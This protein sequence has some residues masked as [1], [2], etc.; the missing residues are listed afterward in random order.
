MKLIKAVKIINFSKKKIMFNSI[1]FSGSLSI[2][3]NTKNLDE[4][5][6]MLRYVNYRLSDE[7]GYQ[8]TYGAGIT[9][10]TA[11]TI[12]ET[13]KLDKTLN[14]I[15]NNKPI[16]P[17]DLP[18]LA[19]NYNFLNKYL[20]KNF[21]G[22]EDIKLF[23]HN[24]KIKIIGTW[25]EKY[26]YGDNNSTVIVTGDYD[27]NENKIFNLTKITP[28]FNFQEMEK[29]W[30]YFENENNKLQVIY[31]WYPLQICEIVSNNLN[32][33]RE[34]EMPPFFVGARGS[35]CGFKYKN[36]IW[37]ILHFAIYEKGAKMLNNS[38]YHFFAVFDTNMKLTKYSNRFKFEGR[39][40][41]FC[42]GLYI[43]KDVFIIPYSVYDNSSRLGIYN[44]NSI[45][46]L[47]WKFM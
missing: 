11:I 35:T 29:N 16:I 28:S 3:K 21:I 32:L 12:N 9:I 33:I 14:I 4:Y 5:I 6:I 36:E 13:F 22:I 42:I 34:I 17:K 2:I 7:K 40:I 30:V 37:F 44:M 41:E 45:L 27:Y 39:R 19:K 24:E 23:N 10:N 47:Q 15:H 43:E 46:N 25:Q 18:I 20:K 31:K 38:Y 8:K 26:C 1:F